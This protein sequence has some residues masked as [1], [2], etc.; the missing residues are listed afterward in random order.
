MEGEISF[1]KYF[2]IEFGCGCGDN[3]EYMKFE[4]LEAAENYA[5][6]AAIE[7]YHSYE[8]YHGVRSEANIAEEMFFDEDDMDYEDWD[9]DSLSDEQKAE[10]EEIY[11]DE[12][13]NSINYCAEEI[14]EREYLIAIGE[15][16]EDE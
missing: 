1:M 16:D 5:Y 12:I 10:V 13:E 14:S 3:E 7:D 2:R 9:W 8:G 4:T 11:R 6:E 15:L